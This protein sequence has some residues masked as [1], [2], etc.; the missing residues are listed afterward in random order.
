MIASTSPARTVT[1]AEITVTGASHGTEKPFVLVNG[2]QAFSGRSFFSEGTVSTT[3]TSSATLSLG[4][5]GRVELAPASSLSLAFSDGRIVG[6]LS[7]GSVSV[8]NMEGVAVTINTPND[9]V[10]NEGTSASRFTVA[11]QEGQTGVAVDHGIVHSSNGKVIGSKDDD[12][13]DDDDDHWKPWATV[14]VIG[15]IIAAVVII[16]AVS[17]DD[18]DTVSPVR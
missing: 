10:S 6:T 2:E 1:A 17:D 7:K 16:I 18:D 15:G 12:D 11:V 9:S 8:S 3:E 13:D 14:A 5:L 4:R